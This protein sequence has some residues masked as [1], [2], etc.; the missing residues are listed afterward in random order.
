MLAV[1]SKGAP[2]AQPRQPL[3]FPDSV[4][5]S[6][7]PHSPRNSARTLI[8]FALVPFLSRDARWSQS[9]WFIVCP[10]LHPCHPSPGLYCAVFGVFGLA[11]S[12][13]SSLFH[14]CSSVTSLVTD[15]LLAR[16]CRLPVSSC[17]VRT[18]DTLVT[19]S[20]LPR[21]SVAPSPSSLVPAASQM[22]LVSQR[23]ERSPPFADPSHFLSVQ[24]SRTS[25]A[26]CRDATHICLIHD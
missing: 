24:H 2:L 6:L 19:V 13:V 21:L 14:P 22:C 5:S 26:H 11:V 1:S 18:V 9:L 4:P 7:C 16:F 23:P 17:L 15:S 25:V 8:T 3:V 20:H 10:R 12:P